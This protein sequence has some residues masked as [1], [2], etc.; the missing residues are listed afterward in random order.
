MKCW[1][2]SIREAD[3]KHVLA[4]EMYGDVDAKKTE[5]E[6]KV[7]YNLRHIEVP[8]CFDCH[9]RHVRSFTAVIAALILVLSVAAATLAAVYVWLADWA[10]ALWLGLSLGLLVAAL[11]VRFFALLG[12]KSIKQAKTVYPEVKE[13]LDKGY[14]FGRRPKSLI[15]EN[16]GA[17]KEN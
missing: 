11:L 10:W 6:T 15:T 13:L 5:S 3:E 2:C 1:F 16:D 8:R 9:S 7:A 4:L 17:D 12:I 14:K